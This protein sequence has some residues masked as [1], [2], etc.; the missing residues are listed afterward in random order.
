MERLS[1][2]NP[3]F[4]FGIFLVSFLGLL[5]AGF[6]AMLGPLKKNQARLEAKID[7]LYDIILSERG[8]SRR[9]G[10]SRN[11]PDRHKPNP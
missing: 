1:A 4:T 2:L 5:L 10:L 9:P 3:L 11:K 8:F 7:R 6:N